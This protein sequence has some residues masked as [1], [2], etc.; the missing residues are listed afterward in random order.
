M[1]TIEPPPGRATIWSGHAVFG[2]RTYEWFYQIDQDHF[3][4][5]AETPVNCGFWCNVKTTLAFK[6]LSLGR[7]R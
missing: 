2:G 7:M 1:L 6:V 4:A 5:R 3:W